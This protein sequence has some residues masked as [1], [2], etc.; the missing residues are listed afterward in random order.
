MSALLFSPLTALRELC[1]RNRAHKLFQAIARFD[2]NGSNAI[3]VPAEGKT[4]Y[5]ADRVVRL[6]LLLL[7]VWRLQRLFL[8]V[9]EE[10]QVIS[11]QSLEKR[12]PVLSKA[13]GRFDH[14]RRVE[15]LEQNGQCFEAILSYLKSQGT[16]YKIDASGV[17]LEA[18]YRQPNPRLS[19][20]QLVGRSVLDV[21]PPENKAS[22]QAILRAVRQCIAT[23]VQTT[24]DYPIWERHY[25]AVLIPIKDQNFCYVLVNQV[26]RLMP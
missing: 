8:L 23:G 21:L 24:I 14:E 22:A 4:G 13:Q 20:E 3:L 11:L 1:D 6:V 12:Y 2:V 9:N 19:A 7:P 10:Y 15:Q 17:Y 25:Q 5:L 26:A 18:F 16:L